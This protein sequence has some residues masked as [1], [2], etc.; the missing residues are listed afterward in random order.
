MVQSS[1]MSYDPEY[2]WKT[3]KGIILC[4]QQ[5]LL[6]QGAAGIPVNDVDLFMHDCGDWGTFVW[7]GISRL[8]PKTYLTSSKGSSLGPWGWAPHTGPGSHTWGPAP[9]LDRA[10]AG[11]QRLFLLHSPLSTPPPA[12]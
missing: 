9:S 10:H 3:P 11:K 12:W 5:F 2:G 8:T 1:K 4:R 6:E 7:C